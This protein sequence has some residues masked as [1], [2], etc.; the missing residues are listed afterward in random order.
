MLIHEAHADNVE[1]IHTHWIVA[2]LPPVGSDPDEYGGPHMTFL[3]LPLG[4]NGSEWRT[5][6]YKALEFGL[7]EAQEVAQKICLDAAA[8][9][10]KVRIFVYQ[11]ETYRHP[12]TG[13][14]RER[15]RQVLE[16]TDR[17]APRFR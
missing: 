9:G 2:H 7:T 13:H 4:P 14:E 6:S 15:H 1:V 5:E 8:A 12:V 11:V 17:T 16:W 10:R 3:G